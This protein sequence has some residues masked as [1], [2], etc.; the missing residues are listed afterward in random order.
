MK[1]CIV[2]QSNNHEVDFYLTALRLYPPVPLNFRT[3][4][5]DTSIPEGGG[6]DR[7]SPVFIPKGTIVA[8]SVWAMHRRTDLWG[9]DAAKFVPE[10][11][12]GG[13]MRG[14]QYLPFNGGPRICLG[15]KLPMHQM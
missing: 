8:Y 14:W 11:W 13:K 9:A 7:L 3:A 6:P 1:V 2:K 15:R 12:E 5:T 10:R 4:L